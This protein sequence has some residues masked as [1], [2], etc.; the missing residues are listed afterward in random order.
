[1]EQKIKS[2]REAFESELNDIKDLSELESIRVS[3]LGKKGS[4]TD[5]LER[6]RSSKGNQTYARTRPFIAGKFKQRLLSPHYSRSKTVR[7]DI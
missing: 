7:A 2:L 6:T 3:Y 5:L 4:I 1:M